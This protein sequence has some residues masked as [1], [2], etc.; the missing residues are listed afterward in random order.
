MFSFFTGKF[1]TIFPELP[2][3]YE[4]FLI[5]CSQE[6]VA[7]ERLMNS[8]LPREKIVETWNRIRILF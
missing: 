1:D 6:V 3:P 8:F 4:V 5:P 2:L 7:G